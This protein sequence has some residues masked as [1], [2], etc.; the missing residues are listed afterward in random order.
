[1]E[2]F[3]VTRENV[4]RL[5]DINIKLETMSALARVCGSAFIQ[6]DSFSNM[7]PRDVHNSFEN[8]SQQLEDVSKEVAVLI[9]S[10]YEDRKLKV[11]DQND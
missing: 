1:M 5:D 3:F 11:G 8:L 7:A 4:N 10:F 2:G 6:R 9:A